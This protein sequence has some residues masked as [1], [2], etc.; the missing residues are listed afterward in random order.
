[1]TLSKVGM[2][3]MGV[4]PGLRLGPDQFRGLKAD[5]RVSDNDVDAFGISEDDMRTFEDYLGIE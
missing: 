1:M 5:N 4:V 2:S 3:A